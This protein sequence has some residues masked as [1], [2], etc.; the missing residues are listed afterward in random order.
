MLPFKQVTKEVSN[1]IAALPLINVIS[2]G[3]PQVKEWRQKEENCRRLIDN[4]LRRSKW[5]GRLSSGNC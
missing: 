1:E 2:K 3:I 4:D 5:L